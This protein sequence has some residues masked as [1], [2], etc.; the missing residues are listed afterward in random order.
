MSNWSGQIA[1]HIKKKYALRVLTYH[2]SGKKQMRASD[3]E[4]Y[5][6][7]ITTYASMATEYMPRG[8]STPADVPRPTGLYS[9]KWRRVVLDE[10]HT[11]RNPKAKQA[12]AACAL[13]ADSRWILTGTPIVNN[14]KDF[15]SHV[16]FLRLSGGLQQLEVFNGALVRPLKDGDPNAN[17]LLQA[18]V[19]TLCLRRMKDMKFVDLHLP[20]LQSYVNHIKFLPHEREK[21]DA[22][23]YVPSFPISDQMIWEDLRIIFFLSVLPSILCFASFKKHTVIPSTTHAV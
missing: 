16:K 11:I 22:F 3:F 13:M 1:S 8:T 12:V 9:T 6:V 4:E 14:L 5:D 20:E 18:L 7:V 23:Q 17:L 15:Y 19:G 21:Y 10:G 2:G